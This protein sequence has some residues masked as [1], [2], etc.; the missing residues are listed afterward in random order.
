MLLGIN[1]AK[2]HGIGNDFVVLDSISQK[3]PANFDFAI[4]AQAFCDRRFGVGAD[5]LLL[6]EA[7]RTPDCAVRMRMWNPDGSEDMCGNGLRCIARLVQV[8]GYAE[9]SF[10]VETLAGARSC[11]ILTNTIRVGMGEP[12]FDAL[13]IPIRADLLDGQSP[14]DYQIPTPFGALN[15]STLS[16]GTT[17]TIIWIDEQ[18]SDEKFFA[19]SPQLEIAELF[20]QRTSLMWARVENQ[21]RVSIRIWERG[22]GETLACGTG[23]CATG[24]AAQLTARSGETVTVKSKGGELEIAWQRGG[25]V[26][27]SGG[28]Q[29]V[30]EG[31][32]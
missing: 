24:V 26:S 12:I 14:L 3:L 10:V 28:A 19:L 1:F 6:L 21:N 22:A 5:G 13:R 4:A 16:T 31:E 15:C 7:A 27:M 9:N 32:T 17:H 23:A 11:E 25:A 30:F 29:I 8:R 2:M 18:L 20:P